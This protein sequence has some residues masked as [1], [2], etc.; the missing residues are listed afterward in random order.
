MSARRPAL[1]VIAALLFA[2][3]VVLARGPGA[4]AAGT[5]PAGPL[6]FVP[7][8][9]LPAT[10][11]VAF[12][13]SPDEEGAPTWAY[14]RI[15]SVP[16]SGA[17]RQS[18]GV[19]LTQTS[20]YG[21]LRHTDEGGWEALTMP[22]TETEGAF[23]K[24]LGALAGE[25]TPAGSVALITSAG[26]MLRN[27]GSE[28]VELL[29]EVPEK[30]GTVE[31]RDAGE[32]LPPTAPG[33]NPTPYA[34]VDEMDGHGERRAGLFVAPYND[35]Q[36][37][38]LGAGILHYDGDPTSQGQ[39]WSREKLE[40]PEKETAQPLA[41]GCGPSRKSEPGVEPVKDSP[42]DSPENCWALARVTP[43]GGET[44]LALFRRAIGSS[45]S[46]HRLPWRPVKVTG[47]LLG[48]QGSPPSELVALGPKAQMLTVTSQGVWVDFKIETGKEINKEKVQV[49][50]SELVEPVEPQTTSGEGGKP[51]Q[52][53]K[54]AEE[55]ASVAGTWCEEH[56]N[57]PTA[58]DHH[59]SEHS[60]LPKAYR[61]FAWPAE[62]TS[63]FGERI[64]TGPYRDLLKLSEGEGGDEFAVTP[65]PGG[66]EGTVPGGGAF[67]SPSEGL[68]ADGAK[69]SEGRDGGGQAPVF[70]MTDKAAESKVAS[71]PTPFKH[72][73]LAVA[74]APGGD[75]GSAQTEAFAV[76]VESEIARFTPGAGW[77]QAPVELGPVVLGSTE[78]FS[79]PT[80]RGVA[81]PVAAQAW[82][83]GDDGAIWEWTAAS[84]A[85][86]PSS[87]SGVIS[88]DLN[89]VAFPTGEPDRGFAVGQDV[90]LN[91]DGQ[92]SGWH[93]SPAP[94][95]LPTEP[96]EYTSVAFAGNEALATYRLPGALGGLIVENESGWQVDSQFAEV[97]ATLGLKPEQAPSHV[98]GLPDGGAVVA[99]P[100]YVIK[101]ESAGEKW[102]LS[103][104]PLPEAQSIAALGAYRDA[105]GKVRALVS[106]GLGPYSLPTP[107]SSPTPIP[108]S[109]YLLAETETGWQDL[110]H[111]ALPAIKKTADLPRR[112]E[113]VLALAVGTGGP[114]AGIAVGGKSG[115]FTG[116]ANSEGSGYETAAA[117]RF[118]GPAAVDPDQS[119]APSSTG[120]MM[121]V[122]GNA[123][124][125][126]SCADEAG[127]GL[128]PDA[129]LAAALKG[130]SGD[131]QLPFLY[132]GRRLEAE[133]GEPPELERLAELFR[134]SG[135]SPLLVAP[136]TPDLNILAGYFNQIFK[137]F[138]P[139]GSTPYYVN[140]FTGPDG[141]M[142]EVF[143]LSFSADGALE[144]DEEG[145]LTGELAAATAAGKVKV[146]MG[147]ASPGF[148]LPHPPAG[149]KPPSMMAD[150]QGVT[151]ILVENGVS[152]YVYDYPGA[153]TMTAIAYGGLAIPRSVRARSGTA[154][155]ILKAVTGSA[156]ARPWNSNCSPKITTREDRRWWSPRAPRSSKA[157]RSTTI[158]AEGGG[159]GWRRTK[160]RY[161]K[162]WAECLPGASE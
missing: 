94:T 21:L 10:E 11:V 44:S 127:S 111:E 56:E 63:G 93:E 67:L 90:L 118:P 112:P 77:R 68:I 15:G 130:S 103:S 85:W 83:V 20:R 110:E 156:R 55:E 107:S 116:A 8:L 155:P 62:S 73:L 133:A 123:A 131:G 121:M 69:T 122:G 31:L 17:P 46:E 53:A 147:N 26:I 65:G 91:Y 145:W 100:G 101:R 88:G 113:S 75:P 126:S 39:G 18:P 66:S 161:S 61:S 29:P 64:I 106:I 104:E 120:A 157:S 38:Q 80:L 137:Q 154:G 98:A 82:A 102:H 51:T 74:T 36:D 149:V 152:A 14:G 19:E 71:E 76:G 150:A 159:R 2:T 86:R 58:C 151:K 13:A 124:C 70:E 119:V 59:I 22:G 117:L 95:S 144:H 54:P 87:A 108:A 115:N 146:V 52:G 162:R 79:S 96:T 47:G 109:G 128:G 81:W 27:P 34:V 28:S 143:V 16:P 72:P 125:E 105:D 129:L 1:L 132:T 48:A 57:L 24:E 6:H 153:N 134:E 99:G 160:H 148:E 12:G 41:I 50:A 37:A 92:G 30:V 114:P 40:L 7:E 45:A 3:V 136:S 141:E 49:G 78:G 142:I 4:G 23:P 60:F 25:A 84:E 42:E 89:A 139:T 32:S 5:A 33:G 97:L 43:S 158:W 9:G 35:G 138:G 135:R 140:E